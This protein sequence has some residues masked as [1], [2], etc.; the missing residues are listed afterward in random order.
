MVLELIIVA[1]SRWENWPPS[2]GE[3]EKK[4][5]QRMTTEK[6]QPFR[7]QD[8]EKRLN[9]LKYDRIQKRRKRNFSCTNIDITSKG[10]G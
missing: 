10:F 5:H 1:K 8:E 7:S 9:A 4:Q 3:E 2:A 6:R